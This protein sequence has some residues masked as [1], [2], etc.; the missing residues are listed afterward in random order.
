M[1]FKNPTP[2][3]VAL[4]RCD[5]GLIA[6]Q[7]GVAP[8]IGEWALPG[9]YVNEGENAETAI[10]REV[11]EETGFLFAAELWAPVTTLCTPNNQLLIFLT[12]S[13]TFE[14]HLLDCFVS[15]E[16]ATGIKV[17]GV[18]DELCFSLHTKVLRNTRLWG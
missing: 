10:C 9:G 18:N 15:N 12:C 1:T 14:P 8:F 6:V 4:L 3:V 11:H 16:E 13:D 7:R 17:V 5:G 2:V